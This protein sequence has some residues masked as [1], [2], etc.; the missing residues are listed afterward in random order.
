M[1]AGNVFADLCDDDSDCGDDGWDGTRYCENGDA[2]RDYTKYDCLNSGTASASCNSE[3][4]KKKVK[5]CGDDRCSSGYCIEKD[6]EYACSSDS[7]CGSEGYIGEA[8]CDAGA[9]YQ[10]Y[11]TWA[12]HNPSTDDAYCR[13]TD[14]EKEKNHAQM[15]VQ[16]ASAL[17]WNAHLLLTAEITAG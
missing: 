3:T 16:A 2:Y 14:E 6:D 9:V 7:G 1:L 8:Y 15:A 5:D 10:A 4:L 12:C 13:Y 17:F 11:R